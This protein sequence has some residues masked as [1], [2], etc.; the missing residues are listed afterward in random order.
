MMSMSRCMFEACSMLPNILFNLSCDGQRGPITDLPIIL[1]NPR[2]I[3]WPVKITGYAK[4][5][6][7][8]VTKTNG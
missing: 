2:K 6:K 5:T 1:G 4:T 3:D 8:M 7:K